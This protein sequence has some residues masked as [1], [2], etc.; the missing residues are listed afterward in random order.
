MDDAGLV[1]ARLA[2]YATLLLAAGVP[3]YL[4]AARERGAWRLA[5]L[6]TLAAV[7]ASTW[8]VLEAIAAMAAMPVGQI[9]PEMAFAVLDATPL[10][11][12]MAIRLAALLVALA[13]LWRRHMGL[14]ALAASVALATMAWTGHAGAG[15]GGT[16]AL[17][18]ASDVVHLLAASIWTGAL[19][20]FLGAAIFSQ[21]RGTLL[22]RLSGFAMIG[23][24][25]VLLLLLTGIANTLAIAGWPINLASDWTWLLGAK[26]AL[27][28]GMLALAFFNRWLLTPRLARDPTGN[29]GYLKLSLALETGAVFLI[30]AIVSWLGV[31]SPS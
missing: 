2:A 5:G 13:A 21:D 30:L 15:E 22:R 6:A 11:T 8:W 1:A 17:H 20:L 18:R 9:D 25:I 7:A 4:L 28:L 16:G 10:G 3:L 12:V 29:L 26:L 23:S 31:L 27:F 14:A 19:T 24:A